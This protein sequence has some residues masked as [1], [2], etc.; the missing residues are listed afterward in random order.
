MGTMSNACPTREAHDKSSSRKQA[1]IEAGK[2]TKQKAR[3]IILAK[4]LAKAKQGL[5]SIT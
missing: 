5:H 2:R 4:F 1:R 3:T